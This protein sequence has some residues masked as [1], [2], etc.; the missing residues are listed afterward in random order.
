MAK[1]IKY[2]QDFAHSF[3]FLP[4]DLVDVVCTVCVYHFTTS[5]FY[6]YIFV[7]LD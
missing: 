4:E 5:E 7:A 3:S 2:A 6:Y 1:H